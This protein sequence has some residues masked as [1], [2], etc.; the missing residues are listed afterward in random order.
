MRDIIKMAAGMATG[1]AVVFTLSDPAEAQS[2]RKITAPA[3]NPPQSYTGK[4][5]V[6]SRGCVFIRA[7]FGGRVTWVPRV[8]RKRKV[9]C[10][11][12]NRPSLSGSQLAALKQA[13]PVQSSNQVVDLS[14]PEIAAAEPARQVVKIPPKK[15]A[16][17]KPAPKVRVKTAPKRTVKARPVT[18]ATAAPAM[19]R[20]NLVQRGPQAVHPGDL[21]RS[22]RDQAENAGLDS[23][24]P[25]RPLQTTVVKTVP[26]RRVA[27]AYTPPAAQT[28]HPG[29]LV[30]QQKQRRL[31]AA[32]AANASVYKKPA[33]PVRKVTKAQVVD[34][35]HGLQTVGTIIDPD[36]T[37]RGD[38]Q[39]EMVWTNTVPRRLIQKRVRVRQVAVAGSTV[40]AIKSS[41]SYVQPKPKARS[42]GKRYVQ[43]GT[44][45]NA[46]NARR[47]I[48]RFQSGGLPVGTRTIARNGKN[49]KV[50]LL[51]PF[52][53]EAQMQSALRSARGAG[54]G[55]AFYAN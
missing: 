2:L 44:F 41:K 15:V 45:G 10:S 50:V 35:I 32:A 34:P 3:E 21:V 48:S 49:L 22:G 28:V 26:A 27:T 30:R 42:A 14:L 11:P 33:K 37:A 46:T 13:K 19:T 17:A 25:A 29:D 52:S 36:V 43:V 20:T 53:S 38:A 40:K 12:S 51:G 4:Q 24:T 55:D 31:Q 6:D 1:F 16:V 7:G 9:Y 54:F 39:M 8:N 5:Y 18:V 23:R 47:T